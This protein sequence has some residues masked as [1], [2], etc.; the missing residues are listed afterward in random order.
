MLEQRSRRA[1]LGAVGAGAVLG[2]SVLVGSGA[3]PFGDGGGATVDVLSAGSL[4]VALDDQVGPAFAKGGAFDY[5]GEFHGSNAV[6]QLVTSGQK[7]PDVVVSA[8]A[9]L[10]RDSLEPERAAWD[11]VFAA[12]EVGIAYNPDTRVGR[13]LDAGDPWYRVLLDS[14]IAAGRT[15]PDLDPLGYRTVMLF[16]LAERYYDRSGLADALKRHSTIAAR[17][18]HLLAS[19]E[20]G[21]RPAAFCYRNMAR[22]HDLP[23]VELPAALNFADP[24]HADAYASA[25]YTNDQGETVRGSPVLYA[26]TVPADAADSTGG[27]AFV[28][29]LLEHPDLLR[30]SGLTVPKSLPETNGDVPAAVIDTT[31][32]EA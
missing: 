32:R 15:D 12:N 28:R 22:D 6:M 8:D 9:G 19:V 4:L 13:R 10:L 23:F 27:Q 16:D 1:F 25:T 21:N 29:F 30:E 7:H 26:A 3:G 5:R 31:A 18:S 11:V 2:G 14:Q 24:A 20:A 17:E